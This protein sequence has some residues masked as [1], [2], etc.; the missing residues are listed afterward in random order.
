MDAAELY[1]A[2]TEAKQQALEINVKAN[3]EYFGDKDLLFQTVSNL[4]DNAIKYTPDGGA[5]KIS[6]DCPS[7]TITLCVADSGIGIPEEERN[8][9]FDRFYRVAKS[10]SIPGN[11]Q[12]LSFVQAVVELHHGRINL[13]D[14]KPGLRIELV[15]P[16]LAPHY[17]KQDTKLR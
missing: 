9:V 16:I 5:I 7:K 3:L 2:L 14:N 1:E 8:H 10:R 4:I 6:L 13:G 15:L 12:G 17:T 11:G